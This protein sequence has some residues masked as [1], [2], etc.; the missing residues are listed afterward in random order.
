ME[1]AP[2]LFPE[3][4]ILGS[5]GRFGLE[6]DLPTGTW[7]VM[8]NGRVYHLDI[9]KV[10]GGSVGGRISSGSFQ[11]GYYDAASGHF[12]FTRTLHDGT[13]QY[14]SAYLLYNV[15]SKPLDPAHRMAGTIFQGNLNPHTRN[16]GWYATLPRRF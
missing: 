10:S 15:L 5:D 16:G 3:T 2:G 4:A 8:A 1:Y 11:D 7:H 14:W 6:P 12:T 9:E 13:P